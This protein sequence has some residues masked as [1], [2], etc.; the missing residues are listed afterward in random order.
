MRLLSRLL[1]ALSVC[2]IAI[3]LPATPVQAEGEYI[4]LSPDEGVPGE[5]ITVYGYNFTPDNQWVDVYYFLNDDWV[6]VAEDQTD[7]V[8]Y[9][10]VNF[11]V[12]ES[13]TGLHDVRAEDRYVTAYDEFTVEPGLTI[14][15]V[16]G[17]V[18]TTVTVEGHGFA[19][20]EEDIE[21]LYYLDGT[22]EVVADNIEATE[23]GYWQ[24][25]FQ[26]PSSVRRDHYISA[27]GA[28]TDL[29]DVEGV[30]FEVIPE[31]N[32][33]DPDSRDIIEEPSGSLAE[34]IAII[35]TGFDGEDSYIKVL[36]AGEE[37]ETDP[38]IIRADEN[39]DWEAT[40]E[41]PDV[42]AGTYIVTAEGL[43]TRRADV[44]NIAFTIASGLV[45]SPAEGHVGMNLTV[46]GGGF[47]PDK[48]VVMKYDGGEVDTSRTDEGGGFEASFLV[49]ESRHGVHNVTAGIAGETEAWAIFIV[50]ND[51]PD[52]PEVISPSEGDR[53]GFIGRFSPTFEWD[54]VEDPSGVYYS[55]R[56]WTADNVTRVSNVDL[57]GANYTLND[58]EA[59]PQGTYYWSIQAVD[60]AENE[61]GW[62]EPR[63]FR[64]G[65]MPLWAFV[66]IVIVVAGGIGALVYFRVIRQRIYYY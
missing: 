13:C 36:F 37:T 52:K 20:D 39:G 65:A 2:F 35:G 12:P 57:V 16:E 24:A 60:R 55:L 27:H 41:V 25:S 15:P 47:T 48:P 4:L 51:P 14:E 21:L 22:A 38:E 9:F 26:V 6:W 34:S 58:I 3:T 19:Q 46:T 50:E 66:I 30:D 23:H 31:I 42:P 40:F 62:T 17:P 32:I 53:I 8:G 7:E 54:E 5:G 63:S 28:D 49:P 64:I 61:S 33:I 43:S 11:V 44:N 10:R 18:D 1:I 45:L 59:L 56:I 29:E